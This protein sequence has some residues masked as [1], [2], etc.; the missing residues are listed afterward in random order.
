M[1]YWTKPIDD[2]TL[3]LLE[4]LEQDD[5]VFVREAIA[6][7]AGL[8][9][10]AGTSG[11]T[12]VG[13]V[14]DPVFELLVASGLDVNMLDDGGETALQLAAGHSLER[15]RR[16]IEL[17]ARVDVRGETADTTPLHRAAERARVETLRLLLRTPGASAVLEIFDYVHR[18]PLICAA[19]SEEAGAVQCAG[20]LLAAGADPDRA[21]VD[22]AGPSPLGVA[23][24]GQDLE[25][26]DLL[27]RAGADPT[28]PTR[29]TS[30]VELAREVAWQHGNRG[31]PA[32]IRDRVCARFRR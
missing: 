14:S 18:T 17:G 25:I 15:T 24:D 31:A 16:L 2:A 20:L 19:G 28:R 30:P 32:R 22:W 21:D 23:I 1:P 7:G 11:V 9:E 12:C 29:L 27:L 10:L 26:V 6:D 8:S 4:A 13:M 5:A 3:L